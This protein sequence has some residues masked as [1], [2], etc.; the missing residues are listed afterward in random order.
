MSALG[1]DPQ[2]RGIVAGKGIRAVR[3]IRSGGIKRWGKASKSLPAEYGASNCER[4][5]ATL[6][7]G[8]RID[9]LQE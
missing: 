8:Y 3:E 7:S 9:S 2:R 4:G 6:N 1:G 5:Y